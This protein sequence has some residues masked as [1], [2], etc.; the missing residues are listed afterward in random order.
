MRYPP[1]AVE[2]LSQPL[3]K[4][5]QGF[6]VEDLVRKEP[7]PKHVELSGI[8]YVPTMQ[9]IAE[10]FYEA[11]ERLMETPKIPHLTPYN[12]HYQPSIPFNPTLDS[13]ARIHSLNGYDFRIPSRIQTPIPFMANREH[14]FVPSWHPNRYILPPSLQGMNH[15]LSS[16]YSDF[17]HPYRKTK[18]IRTAFSPSQLMELEK[19]FE[20]NH[21]VVGAERKELA[22]SLELTETQVKVWFQNR[23]TKYKRQ[24]VGDHIC[25]NADNKGLNDPKEDS[26]SDEDSSPEDEHSTV[27]DNSNSLF[28]RTINDE[29]ESRFMEH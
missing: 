3:I 10:S 9:Q 5:K 12:V 6:L 20:R 7:F 24:P 22:Q 21:Y 14:H 13:V 4:S 2:M 16:Y 27:S 25:S 23:R 19:A 15:P 29:L 17:C 1:D 11:K 8:E 28:T 18:R 26:S